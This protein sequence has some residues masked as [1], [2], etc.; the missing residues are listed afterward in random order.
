MISDHGCKDTIVKPI[1]VGDDFGIYVPDAFS[2]NGD[3]VNDIFQPKGFGITNY[4]LN[5]LTDGASA[6]SQQLNS[7][8]DGME[9]IQREEVKC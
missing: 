9:L 1:L 6:C 5:I 8:K 4:E 2:P 7:H 3:G